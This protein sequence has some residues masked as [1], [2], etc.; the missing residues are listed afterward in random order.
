MRRDHPR[1]YGENIAF[2]KSVYVEKGSPPRI[3]GKPEESEG[4][5]DGTGITPAYT[6]KTPSYR[7][8]SFQYQDHPRVYGENYS[9]DGQQGQL[10]GSPPRIRGKR[11]SGLPGCRSV[12]ITP[13][14][15]G[16][17]E[18]INPADERG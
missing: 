8:R 6:G 15:T 5:E 13:A 9:Q 2:G 10:A 11:R 12:R 1:V 4:G 16:K 3:R 14:Y 7:S 17:T 18:T